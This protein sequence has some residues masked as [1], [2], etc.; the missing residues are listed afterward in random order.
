M[1][2]SRGKVI[3]GKTKKPMDFVTVVAYLNGIQK[4]VT[5][6]DDDG[7]YVFKT[8]QVGVDSIL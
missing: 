2:R 6:T 3:D 8:L 7:E 5:Q 4:A 1:A